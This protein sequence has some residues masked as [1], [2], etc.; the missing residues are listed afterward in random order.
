[1]SKQKNKI[2]FMVD[3]EAYFINSKKNTVLIVNFNTDQK[4]YYKLHNWNYGDN[5][6]VLEVIINNEH[7][8]FDY[9]NIAVIEGW[10]N[11]FQ[12]K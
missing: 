6:I 8:I 12:T 11:G 10:K 1:M 2:H 4:Q 5:W 3:N 9:E 7:C